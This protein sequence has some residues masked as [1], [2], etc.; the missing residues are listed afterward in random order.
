MFQR[1]FFVGLA[2]LLVLTACQPHTHFVKRSYAPQTINAQTPTDAGISDLI[3][4]YKAR[5][6]E[7]MNKVIG[8]VAITL[9]KAQPESTLGNWVA[10]LVYQQ[11]KEYTKVKVDFA[12]VNYGGLRIPSLPAGPLTK[13]KVF[14]LMPFDNTI[15]VVK[16]MGSDL[17][18]LF[19]H[20]AKKG[21][22][23]ISK[24]AQYTIVG[25]KAT[26][27]R[28]NDQKID[29]NQEYL[30]ATNDYIANGGDQCYFFKGK[31]Q[32]ETGVLFRDAIISYVEAQHTPISAQLERRVIGSE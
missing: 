27:M 5:M 31:E 11:A 6:K 30:I 15:V 8:Q 1:S 23:P 7:E 16:M 13:G 21:G 2:F 25:E 24:H 19:H 20:M 17:P 9:T 4:P 14:E 22:W 18:L 26:D 29:P 10:D 3:A 32:L 12:L 28:I